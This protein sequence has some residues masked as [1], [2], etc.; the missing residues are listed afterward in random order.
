MLRAH[1][2]LPVLICA[3]CLLVYCTPCSPDI[4]QPL[5][6]SQFPG[7]WFFAAGTPIN[8]SLSRCG[9]FL[10]RQTSS[11]TFT[12]KFTALSYKN[13]IPIAFNI[14]GS[15][16]GKEIV[17]T[18]QFQGSKRRL[19]P[20]RHVVTFVEYDKVLGMLVCSDSTSHRQGY[21]FA[22]IWSRERSLPLP[23]LKELEYKLGAYINQGRIRLVDH[24][25]C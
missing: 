13:D 7:E 12:V 4:G 17:A 23:I 20:F 11:N 2:A 6:L 16:N 1:R 5:D 9:R 3:A 22:M 10:V 15:V 24:G 14:A 18:W 25:N 19:G 21:K 8:E